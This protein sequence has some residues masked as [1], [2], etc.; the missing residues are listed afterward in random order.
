M[1]PSTACRSRFSSSSESASLPGFRV[2]L[3]QQKL[4][5]LARMAEASCRVEA[6]RKPEPDGSRVDRRRVNAGASHQRA[7]ARLRRA[8]KRAQPGDRERAVL[9]EERDDV[10]DRRERD[11]VEVTARNLGVD[12]EQRLPEL[13]DDAGP[14]QLRERVV[15]GAGRDDRAVGK[16]LGRPVVVGDDDVQPPLLRLGDLG[17]GGDPAVDGED[18][19]A[20]VVRQP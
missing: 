7:E 15:G 11:E 3:G 1:R 16:R 13:V 17:G 19:P 4:E 14:A 12:A 5:R 9:V 6:R 8:R 10:G 18:E 2:V 20:A